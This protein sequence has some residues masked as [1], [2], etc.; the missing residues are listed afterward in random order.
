GPSEKM[1]QGNAKELPWSDHVRTWRARRARGATVS[2]APG[3]PALPPIRIAHRVLDAEL[4][5][6]S[7]LAL[8]F[9]DAGVDAHDVARAARPQAVGQTNAARRFEGSN[10]LQH[11]DALA[12]AEVED[13]VE[14]ARV[15]LGDPVERGDVG[16]G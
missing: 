10:S 13:L 5:P 2:S 3:Q 15:A 4:A 16:S 9:V 11:R 6:P 1:A 12:H 8:R 7:E 14:A